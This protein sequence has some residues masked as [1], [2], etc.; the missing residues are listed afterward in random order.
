MATNILTS[1]ILIENKTLVI[2]FPLFWSS[3]QVVKG[4]GQILIK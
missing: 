3:S 1:K 2:E 4:G